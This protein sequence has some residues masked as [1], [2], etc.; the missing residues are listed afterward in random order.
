MPIPINPRRASTDHT[1]PPRISRP[2]HPGQARRA[3]AGPVRP[4]TPIGA[5]SGEPV[6]LV[7]DPGDEPAVV[8]DTPG[9]D[10]EAFVAATLRAADSLH[11]TMY[12]LGIDTEWA[13]HGVTALT[14][15]QW[16]HALADTP[17]PD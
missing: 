11:T 7:W 6:L 8:A 5:G 9:A 10:G 3:P 17:A 14:V 2:L 13:E 15:R 16:E 4:V 12:T 1:I